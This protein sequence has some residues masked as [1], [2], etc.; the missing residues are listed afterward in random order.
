MSDINLQDWVGK[1]EVVRDRIYPTP[2]KA[3]ALT[4]NDSNLEIGE[5]AHLPEIWHWLYFLP[6]VARSEIGSDG[7]PKR[8]GFLPPIALERR[9]WASGQLTFHRDLMIGDQITK[10]SEILKISEKEG[11]AGKMVF[12]TVKHSI[13]SER[14]V[15]VEEEQNIVYLP[16]PK[17]YT[18]APPNP[19]PENLEWKHAYPTDP[20]LLFRFSALTFNAHRIHYDINYATQ[21]EKY[22]GLVVH[23]PLQALLLLES[24]RNRNP[25]KKPA[26]YEFKAV[27][28]LFDF[29]QLQIGGQV[30]TDRGHDLYAINTD[31]NI[32][33]QAAVSWR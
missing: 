20:V 4:L 8:G 16:M 31:G 6:M 22:P 14:G 26:C 10:T 12:V 17:A 21:I 29:D 11:K 18:S 32:T 24:A 19:A 33:M 27:R 28:P 23:G 13:R 30:R 2:V 15:A 9:M 3:L 25:D 7:H 5:G 1:T